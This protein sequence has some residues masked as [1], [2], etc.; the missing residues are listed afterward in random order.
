[1]RVSKYLYN[2]REKC[3]FYFFFL[4]YAKYMIFDIKDIAKTMIKYYISV[5]L[6]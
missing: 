1:M 3:I 4:F 2:F 6:I 5:Y